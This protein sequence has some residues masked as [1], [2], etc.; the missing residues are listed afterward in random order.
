V[1]GTKFSSA[2]A[3][4]M[5]LRTFNLHRVGLADGLVAQTGWWAHW[6]VEPSWAMCPGGLD[7]YLLNELLHDKPANLS[8]L[9]R[10]PHRQ[11]QPARR[12]SCP[13]PRQGMNDF[14]LLPSPAYLVKL[15]FIRVPHAMSR[16]SILD[17]PACD[18][19]IN[20]RTQIKASCPCFYLF[21]R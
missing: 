5:E 9:R 16:R 19:F 7:Q 21:N 13:N 12:L 10:A 8:A 2:E 20:K 1:P 18:M 15:T 17:R 14:G 3:S 11:T 6:T 4:A